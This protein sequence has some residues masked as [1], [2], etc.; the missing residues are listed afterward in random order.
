M[1]TS[2]RSNPVKFSH[3]WKA[4]F[5]NLRMCTPDGGYPGCV[6]LARLGE[7][8]VH[9]RVSVQNAVL[10]LF[11]L[12]ACG[13]YL[14][15]LGPGKAPPPCLAHLAEPRSHRRSVNPLMARRWPNCYFCPLCRRNLETAEHLLLECPWSRS[16][17]GMVASRFGLPS[18]CPA[19]W[20]V[21]PVPSLV[22]WLQGLSI[23]PST[24]AKA[25]KSV[26]S[27]SFGQSGASV[28]ERASCFLVWT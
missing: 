10:R 15:S 24:L 7:W 16:L 17:W 3:L 9:G 12:P 28:D 13:A 6:H 18:L 4:R 14:A 19:A 1:Q 11:Q 2:R 26:A 20:P 8:I 25:C 22:S 5:V 23:G 27:S 21:P